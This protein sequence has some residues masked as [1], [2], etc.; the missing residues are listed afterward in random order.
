MNELLYIFFAGYGDYVTLLLNT[1]P[2]I[3]CQKIIDCRN[4]W[5][6]NRF[7]GLYIQR[8][9]LLSFVA[10]KEKKHNMI[11]ITTNDIRYNEYI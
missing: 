5:K 10:W 9:T 3:M 2:S 8:K 11:D 1:D 4:T 6:H 7:L